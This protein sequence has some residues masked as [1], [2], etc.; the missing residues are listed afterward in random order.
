[1]NWIIIWLCVLILAAVVEVL[2]VQL[3]AVWFCLGALVAMITAYFGLDPMW[4]VV[5]FFVVSII[6]VLSTRSVV[7]KILI[8]KLQPTNADRLVGMECVVTQDIDNIEGKGAAKVLGQDWTARTQSDDIK[9]FA[10]DKA[11]ICGISGVKL[12]LKP[13]YENTAKEEEKN[14]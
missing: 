2:S 13:I 10:G 6:L 7:K 5:I 12:I 11:E 1:M 14:T 4:Q 8:P 9:L 3:L